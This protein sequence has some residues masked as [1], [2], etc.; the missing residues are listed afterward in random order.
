MRVGSQHLA[1]SAVRPSVFQLSIMETPLKPSHAKSERSIPTEHRDR[2]RSALQGPAESYSQPP[3]VW[4][5]LEWVKST[6]D[7][8]PYRR[9]RAGFSRWRWQ[10]AGVSAASAPSD[11]A[12]SQLNDYGVHS[13]R[14][15]A[16]IDD[17]D[18]VVARSQTG[19]S[20]YRLLGLARARR[21]QIYCRAGLAV[22]LNLDRSCA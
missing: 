18:G 1:G 20:G 6:L 14:S 9:T 17:A 3:E 22:N 4:A 5:L 7:F 16:T 8:S 12:P 19:H 21:G 10:T 2:R 11:S 13:D 15:R